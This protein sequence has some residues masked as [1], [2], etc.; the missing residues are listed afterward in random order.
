MNRFLIAAALATAT[1][2]GT[3]TATAPAGDT[4][5]IERVAQ[6]NRAALPTRGLSMAEVEARY[7]VPAAK[8]EPRGG[9]SQ[10]WPVI[11]RWTYPA[12]T[13]YFERDKVIDVVVAKSGPNEIGPKPTP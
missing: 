7:G 9:Q 4:L 12:F 1:V 5:L 13:V 2:A 10:A 11:N 3:A 6:E 8:L